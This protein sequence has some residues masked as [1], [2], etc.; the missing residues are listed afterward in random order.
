MI[1][2]HNRTIN[3]LRLTHKTNDIRQN[4]TK[5]DGVLTDDINKQWRD[6]GRGRGCFLVKSIFNFIPIGIYK[7]RPV[8][9]VQVESRL[10][11]LQ[12]CIKPSVE[13]TYTSNAI[14]TMR[15]NCGVVGCSQMSDATPS[16]SPKPQ[17]ITIF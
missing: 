12:S 17:S 4:D 8:L 1:T 10:G 6:D 13:T 11:Y 15:E 14:H 16:L 5:Q 3:I 7:A 9:I 2:H